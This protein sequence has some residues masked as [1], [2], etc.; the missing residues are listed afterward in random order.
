[1]NFFPG[2]KSVAVG[3]VGPDNQIDCGTEARDGWIGSSTW[4]I[5]DM[6]REDQ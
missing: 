5:E 1:M 3:N 2:C 6:G 4:G